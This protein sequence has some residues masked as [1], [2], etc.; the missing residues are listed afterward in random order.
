M[1]CYGDPSNVVPVSAGDETLA[2][3]TSR[4]LEEN[5]LPAN[6]AEFPALLRGTASHTDE[7]RAWFWPDAEDPP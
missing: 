4:F 6:L 2:K 5:G 7:Q 1:F 3:W